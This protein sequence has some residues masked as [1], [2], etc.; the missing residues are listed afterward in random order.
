MRPRVD[1]LMTQNPVAVDPDAG[2][3]EMVELM[4]RHRISA[5]PVVNAQG[6]VVGVVSEADLL[7]KEE[8]EDLPP[9][10]FFDT[11]A[12][13]Q[14]RRK[15][16]GERAQDV[17]NSPAITAT[18]DMT[19]VEAAGIMHRRRIKRLPVVDPLG[20]LVGILSRADVLKVFM[21]T[22]EAIRREVV[23]E[24]I[25][26]SLWMDP[27]PIAVTVSEGVVEL[28][29]E[30]DRHSDVE[31]LETLVAGVAGVVGVR[32]DQLAY[33]FDDTHATLTP[34]GR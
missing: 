33:R 23:D 5:L 28:R 31:T 24:V 17:M 27:Q 16:L 30:V 4:G 14:F 2:F 11:P 1:D 3:K 10:H 19:V 26:R 9:P 13:R 20:R 12:R 22:D 21:R 6:R 15:A 29:G 8:R 32:L 7:V 18:P 34:A 25:V